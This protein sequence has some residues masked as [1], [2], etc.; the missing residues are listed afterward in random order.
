MIHIYIYDEFYR[1]IFSR[2]RRKR[3]REEIADFSMFVRTERYL[4]SSEKNKK[5]E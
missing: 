1:L 4:G 2:K 5:N 3:R